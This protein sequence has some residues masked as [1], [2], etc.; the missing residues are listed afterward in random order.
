MICS[1]HCSFVITSIV[2]AAGFFVQSGDQNEAASGREFSSSFAGFALYLSLARALT[3]LVRVVI[4]NITFTDEAAG[5]DISSLAKDF[6]DSTAINIITLPNIDRLKENDPYTFAPIQHI[7]PDGDEIVR[8][9]LP[10]NSVVS[11]LTNN[12]EGSQN[13]LR[14][15]KAARVKV[16]ED[17][18]DFLDQTRIHNNE[19][20]ENGPLHV[21][22][23]SVNKADSHSKE[24]INACE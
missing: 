12:R 11:T 8:D 18:S 6:G 20:T 23:N 10:Y 22:R 24:C 21:L 2:A 9:A 1:R 13:K 5:D 19:M 14:V 16:H 7:A 3:R 4:P 15:V 17:P